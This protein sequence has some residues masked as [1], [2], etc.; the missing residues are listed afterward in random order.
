MLYVCQ[1]VSHFGT[2]GYIDR[3]KSHEPSPDPNLIFNAQ[4]RFNLIIRGSRA[5]SA[6]SPPPWCV[7]GGLERERWYRDRVNRRPNRLT[8]P[9]HYVKQV[10]AFPV[11]AVTFV[12]YDKLLS[13]APQVW[14]VGGCLGGYVDA[15]S[16]CL[17]G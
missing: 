11:N 16:C 9:A 13:L 10:R 2:R 4:T 5:S 14:I 3:I 1:S 8:D 15:C 6:G 17:A 7:R 12:V